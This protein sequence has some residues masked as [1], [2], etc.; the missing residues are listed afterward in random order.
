MLQKVFSIKG[1]IK[2]LRLKVLY[3]WS[4][5]ATMAEIWHEEQR[6]DRRKINIVYSHQNKP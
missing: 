3:F 1:K 6:P 2:A 5:D 4:K